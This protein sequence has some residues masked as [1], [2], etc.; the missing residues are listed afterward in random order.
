MTRCNAMASFT[1]VHAL[2]VAVL[3]D[4]AALCLPCGAA[5]HG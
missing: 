2:S 3:T 5:Q 4:D 1:V